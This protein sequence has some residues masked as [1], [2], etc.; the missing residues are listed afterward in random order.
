MEE[1]KLVFVERGGFERK[2]DECSWQRHRE[3]RWWMKSWEKKT[4][5]TVEEM[6]EKKKQKERQFWLGRVRVSIGYVFICKD[7]RK[8]Q[9][10]TPLFIF[11]YTFVPK[12]FM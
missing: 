5:E 3:A 11:N 9:S 10:T 4:N 2:E 12:S 7:Q 8:F 6:W 1:F